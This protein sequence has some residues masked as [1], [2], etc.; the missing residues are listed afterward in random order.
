[1]LRFNN[2]NQDTF[3]NVAEVSPDS[4]LQQALSCNE[5]WMPADPCRHTGCILGA[6]IRGE[7]AEEVE[8]C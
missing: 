1:M 6:Y 7:A 8:W 4:G 3:E 5:L 2:F